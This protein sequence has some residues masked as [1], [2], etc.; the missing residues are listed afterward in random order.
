MREVQEILNN[1][2]TIYR[3]TSEDVSDLDLEIGFLAANNAP[4]HKLTFPWK[5]YV[6]GKETRK[7]LLPAVVSLAR[8][9]AAK[10]KEDD[11]QMAEER[12]IS[13]IMDVPRMIVVT[14][15]L[16]RNDLFREK[17]DHAATVCSLHN[18]VLSL[19]DLGIGSQWSTGAITRDER[20]YSVLEIDSTKDRIIGFLKVGYPEIVPTNEKKNP[21]E[22][23]FYLP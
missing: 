6:V 15:K 16:S 22:F 1:R 19:W 8:D 5:F 4:C 7:K 17:E 2:R 12:A 14:S 18:L 23:K 11:V 21:N 20:T 13:K 3:F 9:K 10:K